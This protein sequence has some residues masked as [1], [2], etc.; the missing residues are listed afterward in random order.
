MRAGK[1]AEIKKAS[2]RCD[3]M[4]LVEAQLVAYMLKEEGKLKDS[5]RNIEYSTADVWLLWIIKK[6]GRKTSPTR[7]AKSTL[8]EYVVKYMLP[9]KDDEKAEETAEA[10]VDL[11]CEDLQKAD[12]IHIKGEQICLT[13]KGE[14]I[15]NDI[16]E[17][18]KEAKEA[19]RSDVLLTI[20]DSLSLV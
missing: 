15:A 6:Q 14:E 3:I 10:F 7:M 12:V 11:L 5:E 19:V 9:F 2:C 18:L 8:V 16:M 13:Q 4:R 20:I 17:K 1:M